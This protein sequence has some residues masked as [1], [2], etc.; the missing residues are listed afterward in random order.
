MK[1]S[2]IKLGFCICGSFCTIA[3]SL[4]QM[5]ILK[6]KGYEI[7]AVL[8]PIVQTANTRFTNSEKLKKEI[9]EI[10]DKP[11]ICDIV[12]AEPIGPKKMF[13]VLTVCP[14]TGNTLAKLATGITDTSVTMAVKAH[15]RNNKPVVIAPATNDALSCS[16]KT[17]GQLLNMKNYYF[18]PFSQDDPINKERSMIADFSMLEEAILA[19]LE[20]RQITP[21]IK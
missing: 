16:S 1:M 18:V 21:I 12:S 11:I 3:S 4:K 9:E 13:D 15:I 14:C 19:S 10:T 2:S 5:R 7:T 8:S 20:G 6:E 17:I